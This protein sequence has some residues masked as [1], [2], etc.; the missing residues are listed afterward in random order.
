MAMTLVLVVAALSPAPAAAFDADTHRAITVGALKDVVDKDFL[1][2]PTPAELV[3][4][5]RWFGF[6]MA[7]GG[8]K[9]LQ[10]QFQGR[11]ADPKDFDAFGIRRFL[12]LSAHPDANVWGVT[13]A[14]PENAVQRLNAFASG[15]VHPLSD[16]RL[17]DQVLI[18]DKGNARV[19]DAGKPM[20][21]DPLTVRYGPLT[22][23]GSDAWARLSPAVA[24]PEAVTGLDDPDP[25]WRETLLPQPPH[26]FVAALGEAHLDMAILARI[27]GDLAV[28][29]TAEQIA[30][31]WVGAAISFAQLASSPLQVSETACETVR[32]KARAAVVRDAMRTL[33]G[34]LG[35]LEPHAARVRRA[36]LALSTMGAAWLSRRVEHHLMGRDTLPEI[37]A[38]VRALGHKDKELEGI[39]VPRIRPWLNGVEYTEPWEQGRGGGTVLIESLSALAARDA[40]AAFEALAVMVDEAVVRGDVEV[41]RAEQID[42]AYWR[43]RADPDVAQAEKALATIMARALMRAGTA[44]RLTR[45]IWLN[46]SSDSAAR[47]LQVARLSY[48]KQADKRRDMDRSGIVDPFAPVRDWRWL[49]GA[50]GFVVLIL[51]TGIATAVRRRRRAEAP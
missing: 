10:L 47:R 2:S 9:A 41:I 33:G 7:K 48:W 31:L 45:T 16:G 15:S 23:P 3:E 19:D 26:N 50:L 25:G 49:V 4:F 13:Q 36:R 43:D 51:V 30:V 35:T 17:R 42:E 20:P 21:F 14:P 11:F 1:L 8:D 27:Y 5:Y 40:E 44:T 12:G 37:A 28:Q 46:G 38:A 18:D 29:V 6:A 34:Y 22:G 24:A 32:A 39:L